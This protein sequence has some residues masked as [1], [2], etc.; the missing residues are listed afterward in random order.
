MMQP[1]ITFNGVDSRDLGVVVEKLPEFHRPARSVE[2]VQ[3]PGRDGR[4][5]LD[6][7]S[8]DVYT[9][10]FRVNCFGVPLADVYAW[11]S[12]AAWLV[13]SEEPDRAVWASLHMQ[14]KNDRF[15]CGGCYDS[16]TVTAYCQP[17]R[18]FYPRPDS[19]ELTASPAT[20]ANPGT[21]A[22][23]PV[24]TIEGSGDISVLIGQSRMDFEGLTDGIVVD[25]EML[26]CF[27]LDGA[28]L[29]NAHADL[30]DLETPDGFPQLL[31]GGNGVQWTGAV[32][33]I[34]IDGRWRD[35]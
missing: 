3:I 14:V 26:E 17:F 12:G 27:S 34:S 4:L 6:N 11:L 35:L 5:E 33:K 7:E 9:T 15:R 13:S 23:R 16:L 31:P 25:C 24:I 20:V 18:Y 21:A 10:T 22:A 30:S 28:T 32:T 19:V 29:M 1:Y 8:Y 2:L